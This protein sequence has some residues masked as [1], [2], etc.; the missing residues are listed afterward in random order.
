MPDPVDNGRGQKQGITVWQSEY[1]IRIDCIVSNVLKQLSFSKEPILI[2]SLT[3]DKTRS[4]ILVL[5][6][7]VALCQSVTVACDQNVG[8]RGSQCLSP[9]QYGL[10]T[11]KFALKPAICSIARI[12]VTWSIW[13]RT[14]GPPRCCI[15]R[16]SCCLFHRTRLIPQQRWIR[17]VAA[18]DSGKAHKDNVFR[19]DGRRVSFTA[20]TS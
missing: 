16:G 1:P 2:T 3:Q 13:K 17:V 10:A 19:M 12:C 4:E 14:L 9:Q 7:A 6:C 20:E 15:I 18:K 8:A 11:R 5:K